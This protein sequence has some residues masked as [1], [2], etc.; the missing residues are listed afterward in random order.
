MSE[1]PENQVI[2]P[3]EREGKPSSSGFEGYELCHGMFLYTLG[4]EKKGSKYSQRGDE[5]HAVL[6][7]KEE[8]DG[9]SK[10]DRAVAHTIS[11]IEAFHVDKYGYHSVTPMRE[12]RLWFFDDNTG[13]KIYSG[14]CDSVYYDAERNRAMIV[15]YKTGWGGVTHARVNRQMWANAAI[16]YSLYSVEQIDLVMIHPALR[17]SFTDASLV[18]EEI[19]DK[20]VWALDVIDKIM[21]PNAA[22][23][24][25]PKACK[26]CPARRDCPEYNA[27][28]EAG[29][30]SVANPADLA[31]QQRTER[32]DFLRDAQKRIKD[33][34]EEYKKLMGKDPNFV[35][36]YYLASTGST[37]T[38]IKP[39]EFLRWIEKQ[40]GF[41]A[42]VE[43]ANPTPSKA[44]KFIAEKEAID[45]E[46]AKARLEKEPSAKTSKKQKEKT[47][48]K[49]TDKE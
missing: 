14:K 20:V 5:I 34:L 40:Y 26:F 24:P 43:V 2:V 36:S 27:F 33:E 25:H 48:K 1:Q 39:G 8:A 23:T 28:L 29:L 49:D 47:I 21:E 19:P 9:L 12:K 4:M 16:V 41:D 46:F 44:R 17:S 10:T 15:D 45:E 42:I 38:F 3:D 37:E 18:G 35:P 6:E 30:K 7:G 32:L 11:E 31:P 22:R 13:E